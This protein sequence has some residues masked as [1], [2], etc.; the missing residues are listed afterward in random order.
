[1]ES[2]RVGGVEGTVRVGSRGI[3]EVG[4]EQAVALINIY[5]RDERSSNKA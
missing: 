3:I 5:S 1:M 4:E 2:W